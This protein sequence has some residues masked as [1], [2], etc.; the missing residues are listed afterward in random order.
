MSG[1]SP[2]S[3][4]ERAGFVENII[5]YSFTNRAILHE[6]LRTP[7]A[8]VIT[9]RPHRSDGNKDLAQIGDAVLEL[10]LVKDGYED[11]N[12][13]RGDRIVQSQASNR[14]LAHMGFKAGLESVILINPSQPT[15]ST[16]VMATTVEAILGAVYLDSEMNVQAVRA[17]MALLDLGW[18]AC[19]DPYV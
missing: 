18:P 10:V 6:A 5:Q 16:G 4:D 12:V 8:P 7:G 15:V 3:L 2:M 9:G 19:T 11:N 1:I 14:H 13:A 17:V